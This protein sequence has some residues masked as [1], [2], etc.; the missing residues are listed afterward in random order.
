[1]L[2]KIIQLHPLHHPPE[3]SHN[4]VYLVSINRIVLSLL[5]LCFSHL[6]FMMLSSVREP[7]FLE[8]PAVV[9]DPL[10][11]C[12]L[13]SWRILSS[14]AACSLWDPL[15]TAPLAVLEDLLLSEPSGCSLCRSSHPRPAYRFSSPCGGAC[16]LWDP[17]LA[18]SLQSRLKS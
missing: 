18:G 6:R 4:H 11:A 10:L 14:L 2:I 1:M 3:H 8:P 16:S 13:K 5:I 7:I 12:R 15:T 17:F 9:Q